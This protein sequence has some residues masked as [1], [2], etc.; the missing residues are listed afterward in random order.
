M[1][2]LKLLRPK[3]WL[4]NLF[5]FAP[6]FFSGRFSNEGGLITTSFVF[7]VFSLV[8]STVYI[9]NDI[10][11]QE[12][13]RLHPHKKHRP[14]ASG[15]VT[16]WE[17]IIMSMILAGMAIGIIYKWVPEIAWVMALYFGLNV[18]YSIWLKN[19]EI[20][21]ILLIAG[22]YLL[23]LIAGGIATHT[24]ISSWLI[25]CT[26]FLSLFLILAKRK[27]EYHH[28]KR[29]KVLDAY[30][31]ILID[32]LLTISA[33]LTLISYSLYTILGVESQWA[34]YSI[35]FVLMGMFRYLMI[36]YI[37]NEA[38]Y[39]EKIVFSDKI[40][41]ASMIGWIAFMIFIFY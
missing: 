22:F 35:F 11:D 8:A 12:Q 3:H 5:V 20:M 16:I 36:T 31:P 1:N 28:E 26:L 39:P 27:A 38:E 41:L 7:V 19:I 32:H 29:R 6:L 40:I 21:D 4:K 9:I 2:Y 24:F 10:L 23:R 25:L 14:I 34:V 18:L 30:N 15:K 37:S 17:A 33:G 13:D